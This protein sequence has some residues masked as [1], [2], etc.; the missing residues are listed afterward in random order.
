MS[1]LNNRLIRAKKLARRLPA[2]HR[3]SRRLKNRQAPTIL[4]SRITGYRWYPL[5]SSQAMRTRDWQREHPKPP[6]STHMWA[7][8]GRLF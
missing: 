6:I 5:F 8:G 1:R 2:A 3:I 4:D 7:P